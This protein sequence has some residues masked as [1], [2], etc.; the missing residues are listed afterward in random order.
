M[1]NNLIESQAKKQKRAGGSF[2]SLVVHTAVVAA[3]I[4]VTK[5]A[6][7][8]IEEEKVEKLD[9]VE[10]KKDEPKPPEPEKPPPPPPD[11]VAAPPPPKGFQVLSAPVEIPNII[12]EIDLSKK[13]TDEADFSGKGVAGGIAKGVEGGK[14]PIPQQGDQPY[15]DFQVEKPVVMAPGAQGPSYPDMLRSAGIEGTVLAQFVVDTT[16]RAEMATFKALKSDNDLF[17]TS[18]KNALQRMRFLPAEVG[19]R[20]VKQLV[21]QPFQFSLNR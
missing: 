18:V 14:G 15:F 9:F 5:G 21:Q 10:V 17:T 1:F 4:V 11:A 7:A 6:G 8:A 2:M 20:K 12:P 3:L 13:V 16:G 19:G